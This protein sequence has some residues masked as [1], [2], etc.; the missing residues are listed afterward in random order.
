MK[1]KILLFTEISIMYSLNISIMKIQSHA[2]HEKPS[3]NLFEWLQIHSVDTRMKR[4]FTNFLLSI[5]KHTIQVRR[6]C[7]IFKYIVQIY[8]FESINVCVKK[9][10]YFF[11][12]WIQPNVFI[13]L[14]SIPMLFISFNSVFCGI[15]NRQIC[16][17]SARTHWWDNEVSANNFSSIVVI[18]H[19]HDSFIFN[20]SSFTW[21]F[22]SNELWGGCSL[23]SKRSIKHIFARIY[24][25]LRHD[26]VQVESSSWE[27]W[28]NL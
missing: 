7:S 10:P 4:H 27:W 20:L 26:P 12:K 28:L 17:F 2:S 22:V 25:I 9:N 15:F 18:H 21:F 16:T 5:M 13:S 1:R 8:W 11:V 14:I 3:Q 6:I 23:S 19:G 24:F